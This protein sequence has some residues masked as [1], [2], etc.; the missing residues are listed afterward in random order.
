VVR[1]AAVLQLGAVVVVALALAACGGSS[2]LRSANASPAAP[3]QVSSASCE[4]SWAKGT[5]TVVHPCVFTLTDGRRLSCPDSF[6]HSIQTAYS[7]EHSRACKPLRPLAIPAS[8]RAVFAAIEKT[9]LCLTSRGLRVLG[10]PSLGI[11]NGPDGP[12][13]ELDVANGRDAM[14]TLIGYY[15]SSRAAQHFEPTARKNVGRLGGVV[16]RRGE[17]ILVWPHRPTG[18]QR[19]TVATCAFG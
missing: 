17:V 3:V 9:R 11:N 7:L 1:I 19:A 16:Q 13:G 14:P 4:T 8:W 2:A 5:G 10:G 12:I 6:A 15:R 18:H